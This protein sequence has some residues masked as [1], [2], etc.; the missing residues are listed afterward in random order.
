MLQIAFVK[1]GTKYGPNY[2]NGLMDAI[3]SRTNRT[4]KFVC[5]TDDG[6]G[7]SSDI[8][9][10]PF[11]DLGLPRQTLIDSGN[12]KLKLSIFAKGVLDPD[13]KTVYLDLDTAVFGDIGILADHLDRHRTLHALANHFVPHWRT[14]WISWVT[15]EKCYFINSSVSTFYPGDHHDIAQDYASEYPAVHQAMKPGEKVPWHLKSDE[16]YVSYHERGKLRAFTRSLAASFQDV[17]MTPS[18]QL[19]GLQDRLSWVKARRAK[20]VVLTFHG[21]SLKPEKLFELKGGEIVRAG[22]LVARWN[23]PELTS[24]WAKIVGS[25]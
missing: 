17:Y 4:L 14:P 2:V 5:V 7:L 24:Y 13:L 9:V 15:P 1:W 12:C 19:S 3:S 22:H 11:P 20:R 25:A 16:N 10:M 18:L 21:G 23:Y 6:N 8:E